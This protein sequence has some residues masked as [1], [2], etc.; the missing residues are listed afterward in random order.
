M[1]FV[2][3]FDLDIDL[4]LHLRK[5]VKKRHFA[6]RWLQ[7]ITTWLDKQ[8]RVSLLSCSLLCS[9]GVDAIRRGASIPKPFRLWH[10]SQ[11]FLYLLELAINCTKSVVKARAVAYTRY[12][13]LHFTLTVSN[14]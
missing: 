12:K 10:A 11:P 1:T 8:T 5:G 13:N 6:S 14:F 7:T 4:G 3:Q 9:R 2:F